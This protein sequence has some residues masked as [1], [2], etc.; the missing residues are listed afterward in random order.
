MDTTTKQSTCGMILF[1]GMT[2]LDATGPYEVL[3]RVP[4]VRVLLLALDRN[5]VQTEHGMVLVPDCS[6]A[7]APWLDVL[8]IP[9]GTS[10]NETL[11][12]PR[13]LGFVRDAGASANWV[14]SVCTGALLLGA[15]G[16][17]RGYR[18]TTHWR[19][20]A[21][22]T[23]FGAIPVADE[24]VVVDRN[25][26]TGAGVSAG[27]D[28]A[29]LLASKLSDERTARR[30]Q[31]AIEYDPAPPFNSGH[32]RTAS[33]EVRSEVEQRLWSTLERRKEIWSLR[34][35]FSRERPLGNLG[36]V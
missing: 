19:S 14:T 3:C 8:F 13:Y 30:I 31:L 10:V 27:I 15:A 33:A 20:L 6:F 11:L 32:P 16:L 29:L 2:Q 22:L 35:L 28:F 7:E 9:G 26:I 18:A 17:L 21:F 12:D 5:P 36:G 4:E 23:E 24:R 25:R 1:P 34:V